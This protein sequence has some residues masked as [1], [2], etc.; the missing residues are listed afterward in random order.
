MKEVLTDLE[1]MKWAFNAQFERICMSRHMR[2]PTAVF[3][4]GRADKGDHAD[5]DE[6]LGEK[7][8]LNILTICIAPERQITRLSIKMMFSEQNNC[9]NGGESFN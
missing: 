5:P 4:D 6:S 1:V 2:L 8:A 3:F 7:G 9:K